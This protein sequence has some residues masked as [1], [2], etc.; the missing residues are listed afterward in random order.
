MSQPCEP[1][2]SYS[3]WPPLEGGDGKEGHH[4]CQNIVKVELAV[5]PTS[6][7]DNGVVNFSVFVCYIV[8]PEKGRER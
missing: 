2:Y 7:L 5:L 3:L 8:T 6:R 1:W 4:G